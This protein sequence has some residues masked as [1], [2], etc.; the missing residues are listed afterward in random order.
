MSF[1]SIQPNL[2]ST[3][4]YTRSALT[5]RIK[6]ILATR[7]LNIEEYINNIE[8]HKKNRDPITYYFDYYQELDFSINTKD[9]KSIESKIYDDRLYYYKAHQYL[10]I[11]LFLKNDAPAFKV[12]LED[13]TSEIIYELSLLDQKDRRYV[14]KQ[15]VARIFEDINFNLYHDSVSANLKV[16]LVR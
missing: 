7:K 11:G 14:L 16:I 8:R 15:A 5:D 10:K 12:K 13:L 4:R 2:I 6:K 9:P 1:N 3:N